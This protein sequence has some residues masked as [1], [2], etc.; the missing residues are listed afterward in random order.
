LL[1]LLRV[2]WRG[3]ALESVAL[4]LPLLLPVVWCGQGACGVGGRV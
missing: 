2:V 4:F 1:L 3:A